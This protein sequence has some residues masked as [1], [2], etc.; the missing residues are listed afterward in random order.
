MTGGLRRRVG[1]QFGTSV[2]VS[3]DTIV[4][5]TEYGRRLR[6]RRRRRRGVAAVTTLEGSDDFGQSVAIDGDT[7]VIGASGGG[8]PASPRAAAAPSAV[9]GPAPRVAEPRLPGTGLTGRPHVRAGRRGVAAS[10]APPSRLTAPA[11]AGG[12]ARARPRRRLGRDSDSGARPWPGRRARGSFGASFMYRLLCRRRALL[13]SCRRGHG[14]HPAVV[15]PDACWNMTG[16]GLSSAPPRRGVWQHQWP[17]RRRRRPQPL[18][19][20]RPSPP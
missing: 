5:G 3:G 8:A 16:L 9:A 14:T 7:I 13:A 2:D 10:G 11:P 1:R 17:R 12:A 6:L 15:V 18:D 4:V 20:G 19:V